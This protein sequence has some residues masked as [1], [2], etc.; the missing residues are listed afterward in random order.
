MTVTSALPE[1]RSDLTESSPL[2]KTLQCFEINHSTGSDRSTHTDINNCLYGNESPVLAV[3]SDKRKRDELSVSHSGF[4]LQFLMN[5]CLFVCLF[6]GFS[7][8]GMRKK[9][10]EMTL[11]SCYM[12]YRRTGPNFFR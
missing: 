2:S 1:I 11:Y 4:S 9:R 10:Q 6:I 8:S 12:T 3:L 5:V 7:T